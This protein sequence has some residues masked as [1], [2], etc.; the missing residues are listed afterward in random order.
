MLCLIVSWLMLIGLVLSYGTSGEVFASEKQVSAMPSPSQSSIPLCSFRLPDVDG[1]LDLKTFQEK[2][3]LIVNTASIC[4]NTPQYAGL[5]EIYNRYRDRGFEVL[6]FS[7]NDFGLQE[8][9]T[10]DEAVTMSDLFDNKTA[11]TEGGGTAL[12]EVT[13]RE[14]DC[15]NQKSQ[16]VKTTWYTGQ[17]DSGTV[18]RTSGAT[19]HLTTV[20]AGTATAVLMKIACGQ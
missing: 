4:G 10:A 14:Y 17:M 1:R 11:Q 9:G 18:A 2:V 8:L 7:V 15:Q 13:A 19:G 12:S 16:P 5:Q 6:A 20:A 3:L